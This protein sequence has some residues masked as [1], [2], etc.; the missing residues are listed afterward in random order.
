MLELGVMAVILSGCLWFFSTRN[1][2][3]YP[4]GKKPILLYAT[5]ILLVTGSVYVGSMYKKD[6]F[7]WYERREMLLPDIRLLL[8]ESQASEAIK[9]LDTKTFISA[10]GYYAVVYPQD[11]RVWQKL[12]VVLVSLKIPDQALKAVRRFLSMNPEDKDARYLEIQLLAELID[13]QQNI[14][15]RQL[16]FAIQSLSERGGLSIDERFQLA[17]VA[18]QYSFYDVAAHIWEA[19]LLEDQRTGPDLSETV[20][21]GRELLKKLI[22]QAHQDAVNAREKDTKPIEPEQSLPAYTVDL[23]WSSDAVDRVERYMT[24]QD[25]DDQGKL[26]VWLSIKD[27]QGGPPLAARLV[28]IEDIADIKTGIS[29]V[30]DQ[31][32]LLMPSRRWSLGDQLQVRAVVAL[33][34]KKIDPIQAAQDAEIKGEDVVLIKEEGSQSVLKLEI[35]AK[36]TVGNG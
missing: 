33:S 34:A 12:A 4:E 18:Y 5:I 7:D 11:A 26:H 32:D 1:T 6:Q 15:P 29:L 3:G 30:F 8:D 9:A 19:I 23:Q 28:W 21:E 20:Q 13:A 10:L 36:P 22:A 17:S 31:S 24:T 35:I 14:S 25:G 16:L 2:V 27:G